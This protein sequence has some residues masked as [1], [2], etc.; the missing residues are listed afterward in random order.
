MG[1]WGAGDSAHLTPTLCWGLCRT[2]KGIEEPALGPA[3]GS[4]GQRQPAETQ[5]SDVIGKC[6]NQ[7]TGGSA[8]YTT[9]PG[10]HAPSQQ[11]SWVPDAAMG[12]RFLCC[13]T[14]CLLGAGD[15]WTQCLVDSGLSLTPKYLIKSRKEQLTLRCS[16]E[17]GYRSVYWYQQALGQGPQ[18]LVQ[19]YDGEIYQKGNLSDRVSGKQ[20]SDACSEL[21]LIPLELTPSAVYLCASSQDTALHDQVPLG[22][23]HSCPS[24]G[25]GAQCASC[26]P[27]RPSLR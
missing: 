15:S 20:F 25:S 10:S 2:G 7:G 9:H 12:S 19:Y 11:L 4:R 13:V 8:L 21:S 1:I 18:F 3:K 16:P 23:K 6:S 5:S 26:Q 14:L 17:S 27:A 24:S 22:Q